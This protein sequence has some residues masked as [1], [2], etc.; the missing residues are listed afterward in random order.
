MPFF[1]NRMET[2]EIKKNIQKGFES[3]LFLKIIYILAAVIVAS[4]IFSAGVFVGFHRASFEGAWG[5]HYL[6]NFG[7]PPRGKLDSVSRHFSN[8]HGAVGSIIQVS[9]PTII[10]K[11]ND[12]TEKII[13]IADNTDI[14]I[15]RDG[16]GDTSDLQVDAPIVVIGNPNDQGQIEAKFIRVMPTTLGVDAQ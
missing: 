3:K 13:L 5:E 9:L 11:D 16:E 1:T 15:G 10:V 12:G 2:E 8:P 6:E 7:T 4:A 14:E